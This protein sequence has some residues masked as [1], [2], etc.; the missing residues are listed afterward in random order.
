MR[1]LTLLACGALLAGCIVDA[2]VDGDHDRV[3]RGSGHTA[4]D[5]RTLPSFESVSFATE[6]T[7]SIG[8]GE[9]ESIRIVTDDNLLA[10][11]ETYVREGA[12]HIVVEDGYDLRPREAIR[13]SLTVR[14]I[15]GVATLGS[16]DVT[17]AQVDQPH[18]SAVVLG[19]GDVRID[20][21]TT[22]S[23]SV[24]LLGSGDVAAAGD[25]DHLG[26]ALSGSGRLLGRELQTRTASIEVLGSG[27][28]T[29]R[30]SE[31]LNV[32]ILGSGDVH[33]YGSPTVQSAILGSGHVVRE[34]S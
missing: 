19:S 26:V 18:F 13:L 24:A 23:F 17:V 22:S 28:A 6:G 31:S 4:T 1:I 20:D 30:V 2:D 32:S 3:V 29:L 15:D 11:I 27:S 25:T 34:G 10:H 16:G 33:Y 5:V 8:F 21:L 9:E 14:R 7:L 12:L